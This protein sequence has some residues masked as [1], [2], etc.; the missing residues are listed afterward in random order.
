[1]NQINK[2]QIP[3]TLIL[4]MK[5]LVNKSQLEMIKDVIAIRLC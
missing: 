2:I 1:M 3:F 4:L 5:P